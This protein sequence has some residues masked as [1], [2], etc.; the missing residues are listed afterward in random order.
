MGGHDDRRVEKLADE[1]GTGVR[2]RRGLFTARGT[3]QA[4]PPAFRELPGYRDATGDELPDGFGLGFWLEVPVVDMT[5]YLPHLLA[6]LEAAGATVT[7]RRVGSL[8][9]LT[10][11]APVVVHCAGIGAR[12][13][14]EDPSVEP[15]WGMHAIVDATGIDTCF[16][17]GPPGRD[18]WVGWV[19][20]GDRLLVGGVAAPGRRD[21]SPDADI[22]AE[23]VGAAASV[24]PRLRG[25]PVRDMNAGLR[26]SRPSIRVDAEVLDGTLVVHN[27]GHGGQGVTLS[28]GC[29]DEVVSLA[30]QRT[31]YR[32]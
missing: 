9:E 19:P 12:E 20:H 7:T 32:I 24:E 15:V 23:L 29:A 10:G 11:T 28:W 14:A 2:R 21:A 6:R 30:E 5:R 31:G 1:P 18:R 16:H 26:P 25:R 17:E 27:Y 22:A 13:L 8:G 4:P 3:D